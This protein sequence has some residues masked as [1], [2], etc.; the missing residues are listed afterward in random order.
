[1]VERER[2]PNGT[3]EWALTIFLAGRECPFTCVYCDLWRY[4]LD[5]ATPI[6]VLVMC[7]PWLTN[8]LGTAV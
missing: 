8:G 6:A 7:A 3:L 4:T 1:M 2:T 5:E